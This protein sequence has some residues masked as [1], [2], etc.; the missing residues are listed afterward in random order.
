MFV[1]GRPASGCLSSRERVEPESRSRSP[2]QEGAQ[3]N[4]VVRRGGKGHD[5]I[6]E[7]AA[8]MSQL[9]QPAYRFHP[10]EDLLDQ[11]AFLLA[12]GIPGMTSRSC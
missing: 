10:A 8:P 4:Q 9:P 11:L 6:D 12:D 3:A 1:G 2:R 5:P 7:C